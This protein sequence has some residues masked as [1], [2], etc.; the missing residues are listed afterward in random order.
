MTNAQPGL[1][2]E[3]ALQSRASERQEIV[4]F[5]SRNMGVKFSTTS[6]HARWLTF[7]SRKAEINADGKCPIYIEQQGW[8]SLTTDGPKERSIFWAVPRTH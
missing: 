5:L 2:M 8:V 1:Q 3:L 6:L 7:R 4:E